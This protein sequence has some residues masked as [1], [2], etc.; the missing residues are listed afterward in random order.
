MAILAWPVRFKLVCFPPDVWLDVRVTRLLACV[1]YEQCFEHDCVFRL[2]C[3][4]ESCDD[5]AAAGP[6]ELVSVGSPW[7]STAQATMG[8]SNQLVSRILKMSLLLGH[9]DG[10]TKF[11]DI[12]TSST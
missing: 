6:R 11:G 5:A 4:Q 8:C 10:V 7:T 3:R 2:T 12:V 9:C 1:Q